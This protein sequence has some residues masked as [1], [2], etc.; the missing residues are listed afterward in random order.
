MIESEKKRVFHLR[1]RVR[2]N[3][4]TETVKAVKRMLGLLGKAQ[5]EASN[6]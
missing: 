3:P 1:T 5:G 6:D 2:A 4:R